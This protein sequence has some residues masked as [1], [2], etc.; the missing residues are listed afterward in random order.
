MRTS[1][2]AR[3]NG[4]ASQ[5][6]AVSGRA[7]AL[8]N[9]EPPGCFLCRFTTVLLS[10]SL[11]PVRSITDSGGVVCG[12]TLF[13]PVRIFSMGGRSSSAPGI[14]PSSEDTPSTAGSPEG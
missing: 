11:S 2:E 4:S 9:T 3:G 13:V 1:G 12:G 6:E 8:R 5:T 14:S 7:L 10:L